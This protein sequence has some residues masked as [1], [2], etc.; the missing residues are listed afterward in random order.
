MTTL[1]M[2]MSV[3]I[4]IISE[5]FLAYLK[6][7]SSLAGPDPLAEAPQLHPLP[8]DVRWAEDYL[9]GGSHRLLL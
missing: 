2:M 1:A 6:P 5:L 7:L 4:I 9:A 3:L 8:T